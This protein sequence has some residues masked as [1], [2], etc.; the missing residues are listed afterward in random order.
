M[1]AI[2]SVQRARTTASSTG[3]F[4]AWTGRTG[5]YFNGTKPISWKTTEMKRNSCRGPIQRKSPPQKC[6]RVRTTPWSGSSCSC[7]STTMN[8]SRFIPRRSGTARP[9][10]CGGCATTSL[11]WKCG[12]SW[13][14]LN[15]RYSRPHDSRSF[16]RT[17]EEMIMVR[18][19]ELYSI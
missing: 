2:K 5:W 19:S 9:C 3:A 10:R 11:L 18:R 15:V 14:S 13:A 4:T 16:F 17:I 6:R 7:A 12:N 8:P 1:Q